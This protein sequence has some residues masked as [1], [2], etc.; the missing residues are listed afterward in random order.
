MKVP[1]PKKQTDLTPRVDKLWSELVKL[2]AGN[3]CEYCG[4][5]KS[6]NSHH[7]F[8]KSNRSVRWNVDNG[9]ALCALHHTLG[10]ES[11]HK[12]PL[13]FGDWI[14]EKRGTEWYETLRN[15]STKIVKQSRDEKMMVIALLQIMIKEME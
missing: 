14:K 10:N 11:A 6:L 15:K 3:K 1:K 8:S 4:S 13:S 5:T 2:R 12:S 9:I 7:I